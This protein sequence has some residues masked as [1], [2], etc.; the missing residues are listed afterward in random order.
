MTKMISPSGDTEI[1]VLDYKVENFERKGWRRADAKPK[2]Q[3]KKIADKEIDDGE[4]Q[5]L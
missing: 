2:K 4:S 1:D 5:G 3:P